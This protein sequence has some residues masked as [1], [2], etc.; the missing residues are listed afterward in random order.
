MDSVWWIIIGSIA[1]H[2]L[3]FWFGWGFGN[4]IRRP[5]LGGEFKQF[6]VDHLDQFVTRGK[7]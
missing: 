7:W 6:I 4:W 2:C 1:S 5:K 3:F